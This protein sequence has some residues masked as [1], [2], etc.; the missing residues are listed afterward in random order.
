MMPNQQVAGSTPAK[1]AAAGWQ[2]GGAAART[3]WSEVARRKIEALK[4][5]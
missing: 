3:R 1:A 5:R 4:K 2:R